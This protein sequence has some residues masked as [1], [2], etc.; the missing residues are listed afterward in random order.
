MRDSPASMTIAFTCGVKSGK[1]DSI[2]AP[3]DEDT[4]LWPDGYDGWFG[5]P[6]SAMVLTAGSAFHGR[7]SQYV[8]FASQ[9]PIVASAIVELTSAKR[10]VASRSESPRAAI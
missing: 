1:N 2:T 7:M 9:Q 5:L 4:Q 10:C 6:T 8:S 3:A